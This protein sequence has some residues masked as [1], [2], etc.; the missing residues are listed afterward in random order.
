MGEM[1]VYSMA[2]LLHPLPI[3]LLYMEVFI[4]SFAR[5]WPCPTWLNTYK[6]I[7]DG[8][9]TC[10]DFRNGN[11]NLINDLQIYSYIRAQSIS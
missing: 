7:F 6:Q 2:T 10:I 5:Q 1:E 9:S 11:L 8:S 3:P 4:P